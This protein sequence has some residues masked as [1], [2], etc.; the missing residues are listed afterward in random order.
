MPLLLKHSLFFH[1]IFFQYYFFLSLLNLPINQKIFTPD[2][3]R[4]LCSKWKQT[5][6]ICSYCEKKFNKVY[7][8]F[9]FF[10]INQPFCLFYNKSIFAFVAEEKCLK[11]VAISFLKMTKMKKKKWKL[12]S[13]QFVFSC[14]RLGKNR[15]I[16]G[17]FPL[18]LFYY[19]NPNIKKQ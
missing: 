18:Q 14:E 4:Q 2:Y 12:K 7:Y 17:I 19:M 15:F 1:T 5:I 9:Y 11:K 8:I 13:D 10:Y 16:E 3:C 6:V